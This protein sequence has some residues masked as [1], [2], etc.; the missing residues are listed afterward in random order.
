MTVHVRSSGRMGELLTPGRP[1]LLE[2]AGGRGR[3]TGFTLALARLP[4]GYV[5]LD[6]HLP[7][8]LVAAALAADALPGFPGCRLLR[9]EPRLGRHRLDFLLERAGQPWLLEVKSVTLVREGAALFP[10]AP[11]ARGRAHLELLAARCRGGLPG[12]VLFVVQRGD[13]VVFRPNRAA[14]PA[15]AAAL[16]RAAQAGVRIRACGAAVSPRGVRLAG[17]LPVDLASPAGPEG[18]QARPQRG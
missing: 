2:P 12:G 9:V 10:D 7:N 15:F 13:A 6:A 5:S 11:T 17:P 1:L 14:D 16:V 3:R 8:R 18:D 4:T